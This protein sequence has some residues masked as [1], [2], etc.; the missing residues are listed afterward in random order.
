MRMRGVLGWTSSCA[1]GAVVVVCCAFGPATVA[2]TVAGGATRLVTDSTLAAIAVG[3][4]G[5]CAAL[6]LS[7]RIHSRG[8]RDRE[9]AP[10]SEADPTDR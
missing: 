7:L 1:G 8:N 6:V 10:R 9:G 5:V 3:A 2:G 4:A